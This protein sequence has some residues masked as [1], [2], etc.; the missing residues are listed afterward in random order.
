LSDEALNATPLRSLC[1]GSKA[2]FESPCWGGIR[3]HEANLDT[4]VKEL[5]KEGRTRLFERL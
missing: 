5:M 4:P 1:Y 3:F 2:D